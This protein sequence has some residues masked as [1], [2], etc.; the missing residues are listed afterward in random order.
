MKIQLNGR[1][2]DLDGV[3]PEAGAIGCFSVDFDATRPG[4]LSSNRIG[5]KNAVELSLRYNI[6]MT[7]AI[8]GKTAEED[9]FAYEM[10]LR[11]G[12]EHEIAVHTYSHLDVSKCSPETLVEEVDRCI[13]VLAPARRPRTFI[14]PWNREG[15]FDV[16][17]RLGFTAYR[18]ADR[19]LGTPQKH[20]GMWNI[21]PVYYLG[22][23]SYGQSSLIKKFIALCV[24]SRSVFHLWFH[25]WS[26]VE[27]SP[28]A[29]AAD[30]LE[31]VFK[32]LDER[33]REGELEL[34][35][36]GELARRLEAA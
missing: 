23:L 28:E 26:I 33:R 1:G 27:P 3:M 2:D 15:H 29:F 25:P 6:P 18:G 20:N 34:V 16:L 12:V 13:S 32:C 17:A 30:I 31:P 7:W 21:P 19:A 11:S 22:P 14:F 36:L 35:T 9:P 10:V 5:T 4:R 8:C 24:A